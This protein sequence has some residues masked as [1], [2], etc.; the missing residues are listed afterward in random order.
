MLLRAIIIDDEP[1]A[2]NVLKNYLE[3]LS[4]LL[5][6]DTFSNA[7][8][9]LSYL[10]ENEVDVIFLDINMPVL[11]GLDFIK[12]L[13]ARPM[14]ILTTAH[15][16]YALKG[17]E[18]DVVDYLVKPIPFP[19]FLK[20]AN[21]VIGLYKAFHTQQTEM[22]QERPSIF[23]KID[24][25]KLQKIFLDEILVMESLKDYVQIKTLTS[26]YI[27]YQT[28]GNI[29]KALPPDKFIRIHRSFTVALDKIDSV[30]G[31]SVELGNMRY[32]IGRNYLKDAKERIF[33]HSRIF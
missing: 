32:V 5:L 21:K 6:V 23:V 17:F 31:N 28:L 8:S 14:V 27:V 30:E 33:D 2:I 26:K 25:K 22:L 9:A 18:L 19:K 20:S 13:N 7:V 3:Q 11:N 16:Q 15:S 29:T 4:E 12:S 10:R 1:L 24:R